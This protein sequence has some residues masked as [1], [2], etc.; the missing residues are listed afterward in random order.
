MNVVSLIGNLASDVDL[1]E[2]GESKRVA[3]FLLA[4]DRASKDG[5]ADFVRVTVWDRQAE[6]CHRFLAKGKRV[7]LDGRLRSRSWQD[8]D[9]ARRTAVEVVANRVEFLSPPD[10]EVSAADVPFAAAAA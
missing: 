8:T 6:L 5:G 3:T 2:V 10:G 9:G 7:G 1:K 4:I